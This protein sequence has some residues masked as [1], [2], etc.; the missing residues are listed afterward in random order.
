MDREEEK[1]R[2]I[3]TRTLLIEAHMTASEEL[4]NLSWDGIQFGWSIFGPRS[5]F[6]RA[7]GTPFEKISTFHVMDLTLEF[8]DQQRQLK[9]FHHHQTF[10][11][12][13]VEHH[14]IQ[15]FMPQFWPHSPVINVSS[16][17]LRWYRLVFFSKRQEL[18]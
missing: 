14:C 13:K 7:F 5:E 11:R 8:A 15:N 17:G 12:S 4:P 3:K 9:D 6:K 16:V 2:K 18:R 10:T 1:D